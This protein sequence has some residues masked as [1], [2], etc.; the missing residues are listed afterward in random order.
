MTGQ[1]NRV[2]MTLAVVSSFICNILYARVGVEKRE[3]SYIVVKNVYWYNHNTEK[4]GG[5]LRN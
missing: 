3:R 2:I 5:S 4:Y 1:G